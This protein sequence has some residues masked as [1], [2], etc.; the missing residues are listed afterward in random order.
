M[1]PLSALLRPFAVAQGERLLGDLADVELPPDAPHGVASPAGGAREQGRFHLVLLGDATATGAGA[2]SAAEGLPGTVGQ[3]VADGLRREVLWQVLAEPGSSSLGLHGRLVQ[4]VSPAADAVVVM[5]GMHDVLAR[6]SPREWREQLGSSLGLLARVPR[7][8]VAGCP[9]LGRAPKLSW[10]LTALLDEDCRALDRASDQVC[11]ERGISFVG[12]RG[13][14]TAA[15][16]WADDG[17]HLGLAGQRRLATM[18][19][20]AI[21]A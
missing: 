5:V 15:D 2:P 19:A 10:P 3:T 12:L 6:T 1:N 16:D 8:V 11:A 14:G 9:P 4:Q 7:V 17:L 18:L 20:A 21:L 13:L